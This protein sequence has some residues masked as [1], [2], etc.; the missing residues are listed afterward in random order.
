MD[1][2]GSRLVVAR[3]TAYDTLI[4]R[5]GVALRAVGPQAV[6]SSGIYREEVSIVFKIILRHALRM[7][8]EASCALVAVAGHAQV[9]GIDRSL[10]VAGKARI[11]GAVSRIGVTRGTVIPGTV[12]ST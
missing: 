7:A 12:V 3:Q 11:F 9:D 4:S 10:R 5:V 2:I 8:R 1:S 6:M